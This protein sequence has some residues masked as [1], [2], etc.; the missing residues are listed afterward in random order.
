MSVSIHAGKRIC[1]RLNLIHNGNIILP[2]HLDVFDIHTRHVRTGDG[3]TPGGKPPHYRVWYLKEIP[4]RPPVTA[5]DGD[6]LVTDTDAILTLQ[7]GTWFPIDTV[8]AI[9][10]GRQ[11]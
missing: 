7:D 9:P 4:L 11:N 1:V 10:V 3:Y 5:I 8:N 6:V 2:R